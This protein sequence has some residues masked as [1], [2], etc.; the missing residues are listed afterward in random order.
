MRHGR[1]TARGRA[2]AR[3]RS[4]SRR[5][6]HRHHP[7]PLPQPHPHPPNHPTAHP[8]SAAPAVSPVKGPPLTPPSQGPRLFAITQGPRLPPFTSQLPS[9]LL[10]EVLKK[11]HVLTLLKIKGVSRSWRAGARR[12]LWARLCRRQGQPVPTS[13]ATVTDIDIEPFLTADGPGV[14]HVAEAMGSSPTCRAIWDRL[15]K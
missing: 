1:W 9:E 7:A 5:A 3:H 15:R 10:D 8:S 12:V 14:A 13:R 2:V 4:A 6:A 11:A